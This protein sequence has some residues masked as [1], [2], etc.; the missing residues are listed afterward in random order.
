MARILFM[1]T[2][3]FSLPSLTALICHHDVAA[4]VTQPDRGAGRNRRPKQSPVKGLALSHAIPVLQPQRLRQAE[5]I[6]ELRRF[7]ADLFVVVAYGQILPEAALA[8]PRLGT[9][10]VH[11]SLLPRWR[12][13]APIQAALRAG[14]KHTG[15]TIMLMDAGLDTGPILSQRQLAID[16][17]DTG[18][19]LHGKLA[20]I[21]ADLLTETIPR[22]LAGE[23]KPIP[24]DDAGA[25]YAPRIEKEEGEIDW[26]QPAIVIDRLVRAFTP[27]PGSYTYVAGE[28]LKIL[29]GECAEGAAPV[30]QVA[31]LGDA[32][33]IGTGDGLYLL[34]H[35]QKPGKKPL[36]IADFVR[37][38]RGFIGARLGR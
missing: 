12:G 16:A 29:A 8:L 15:A 37:G 10:N 18:A 28:P 13:A 5:A 2:P 38:Q 20:D 35:V 4:V 26:S 7:E 19:S 17:D 6:D 1:G 32:I 14:D 34:T 27:W 9:L 3:E 24:Q 21:G 23:I 36:A 30:G 22:Y 33:G 25:S 11:A 31:R